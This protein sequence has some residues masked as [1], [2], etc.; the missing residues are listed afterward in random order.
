MKKEVIIA[1]IIGTCVG[2]IVTVGFF[3]WQNSTN[4]N[5]QILSP[6]VDH[7]STQPTPAIPPT[8]SLTLVSPLDE[9]LTDQPK[10]KIIGAAPPSSWILILGE[11]GEKV[12]QTDNQG[13][14]E[15]E[16][17]LVSGENEIT[18]KCFN[19]NQEIS[20]KTITVVYTT[21]EI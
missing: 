1:I 2:L 9:S 16:I 13:N 6:L 12:V 11:K 17:S 10:T 18:I 5:S 20:S 3:L 21:A 14:F 7:P 19:E 8:A 4:Q 15:T